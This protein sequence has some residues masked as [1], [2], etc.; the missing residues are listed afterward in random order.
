MTSGHLSR[1]VKE[2][3]NMPVYGSEDGPGIVFNLGVFGS[4]DSVIKSP[5]E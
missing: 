4:H 3:E 1:D 2:A 5:E